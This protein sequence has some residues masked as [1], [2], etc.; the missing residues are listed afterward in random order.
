MI[1]AQHW[2][3]YV[4]EFHHRKKPFGSALTLEEAAAFDSV[5]YSCGKGSFGNLAHRRK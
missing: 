2:E 4:V 3:E 1:A 5:A